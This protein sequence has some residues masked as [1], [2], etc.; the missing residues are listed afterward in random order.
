MVKRTEQPERNPSGNEYNA[1]DKCRPKG[2]PAPGEPEP[3]HGRA[4]CH[5]ECRRYR[6]HAIGPSSHPVISRARQFHPAAVR[7]IL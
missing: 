2:H 5:D 6:T 1:A 3:E 4:D 7:G